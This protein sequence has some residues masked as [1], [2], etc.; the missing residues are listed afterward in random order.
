[1]R[2]LAPAKLEG[3]NQGKLISLI[4]GDIEL[5]EVFYAHT[6]SPIMIAF[7]VTIFLMYFYVQIHFVVAIVA[8]ISYITIG[9]L[10]PLDASRRGEEVGVNIR[11][12]IG[13]LN[14]EF[15]DKLRGIR[16]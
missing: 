10:V 3:E 4:M 1:M 6:I 12:N 16:E 15:L 8:F 2:R 14:G 9:V 13:L 11:R 7:L 5:L